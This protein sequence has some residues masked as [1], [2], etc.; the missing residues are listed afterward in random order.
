MARSVI[1]VDQEEE[2]DV[3]IVLTMIE[4]Q[5][6]LQYPRIYFTPE[7]IMHYRIVADEI[8]NGWTT[9]LTVPYIFH[10]NLPRK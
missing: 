4:A 1:R 10:G 3:I 8:K 6:W 7:C 9:H 5:R 2:D